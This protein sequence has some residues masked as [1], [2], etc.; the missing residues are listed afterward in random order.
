[1]EQSQRTGIARGGLSFMLAAVVIFAVGATGTYPS[2][3]LLAALVVLGVAIVV[4]SRLLEN[5]MLAAVWFAPIVAAIVLFLQQDTSSENL[6]TQSVVVGAI[7][8]AQVL[9]SQ[10]GR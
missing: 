5:P 4:A 9:F 3:G 1:M 7:G 10:V 2:D 8:V 6:V